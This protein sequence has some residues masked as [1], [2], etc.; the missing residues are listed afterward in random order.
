MLAFK[1]YSTKTQEMPTKNKVE[2]NDSSKEYTSN[3]LHNLPSDASI[4][5]Q[6]CFHIL[7]IVWFVTE[8][9]Q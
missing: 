4:I 1:F 8:E 6:V 5:E 2:L 7:S 3:Q 9:M